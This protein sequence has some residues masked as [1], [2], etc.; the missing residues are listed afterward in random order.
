MMHNPCYKCP[1]SDPVIKMKRIIYAPNYFAKHTECEYCAKRAEYERQK[2]E[3]RKYINT[4]K[5]IN[6]IPDFIKYSENHNFLFWGN[7]LW[8]VQA[9]K[10]NQYSTIEYAIIRKNVYEAVEREVKH[11]V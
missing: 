9:F 4:L 2:A 3:N 5:P 6:S 7:R 10:Q 11:N 1:H 8:H